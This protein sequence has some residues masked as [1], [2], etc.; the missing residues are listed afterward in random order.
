MLSAIILITAP[1]PIVFKKPE[2]NILGIYEVSSIEISVDGPDH[3]S[4]ILKYP[5]PG[6]VDVSVLSLYL[7]IARPPS[8]PE[9][10][11]VPLEPD[12]PLD[13]EDPDVPLDPSI[14]EVPSIPL[15]PLDPSTPLV[16]SIPDVPSIPLV[17]LDPSIP[18][19]P[20]DPSTPDVPEDPLEPVPP[21]PLPAVIPVI[22]ITSPSFLTKFNVLVPDM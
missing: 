12:V 11:D 19:V 17:P 5:L 21:P 22:E 13:P 3:V 4:F 1:E 2:S 9:D 8:I 16:P 6:S 18:L 15:V 20:E 7:H 14:P 10:P